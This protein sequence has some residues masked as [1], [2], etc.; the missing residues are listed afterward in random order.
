MR[1]PTVVL[2]HMASE[3]PVRSV[4]VGGSGTRA[5]IDVASIAVITFLADVDVNFLYLTVSAHS[6]DLPGSLSASHN[7]GTAYATGRA[8]SR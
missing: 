4:I 3:W 6:Q 7:S 2:Q 8:S 5:T 1:A